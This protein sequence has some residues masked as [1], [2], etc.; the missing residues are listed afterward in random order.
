MTGRTLFQSI[1][2]GCIP[3]LI[4]DALLSSSLPLPFASVIDWTRFSIRWPPRSSLSELTRYLLSLP[5]D[6]VARYHAAVLHIRAFFQWLEVA[7]LPPP[8]T[9]RTT[10]SEPEPVHHHTT[11]FAT[12]PV[13]DESNRYAANAFGLVMHELYRA[14]SATRHHL[15]ATAAAGDIGWGHDISAAL[16]LHPSGSDAADAVASASASAPVAAE[17]GTLEYETNRRV[18]PPSPAAVP[19]IHKHFHSISAS[20]PAT[21]RSSFYS[22]HAR[23]TVKDAEDEL[24]RVN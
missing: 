3:V 24:L 22:P 11:D 23:R 1:A 7:P 17:F 16:R 2:A 21:P 4:G 10:S 6:A 20:P 14:R 13:Q 8:L 12:A 5:L 19:S 15:T 9:T 18:R